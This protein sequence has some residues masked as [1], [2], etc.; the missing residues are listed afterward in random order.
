MSFFIFLYG[1][2][3]APDAESMGTPAFREKLLRSRWGRPVEFSEETGA[4]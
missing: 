4:K 1:C 3:G 2:C